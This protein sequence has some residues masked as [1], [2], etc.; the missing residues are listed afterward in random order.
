MNASG[1]QQKLTNHIHAISALA[2]I[3]TYLAIREAKV[4]TWCVWPG[5]FRGWGPITKAYLEYENEK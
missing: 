2:E 3:Q 4:Q 5:S 1:L